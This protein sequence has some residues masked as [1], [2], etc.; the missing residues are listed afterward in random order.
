MNNKV[1][2]Q[3]FGFEGLPASG[4]PVDLSGISNETKAN[5]PSL[6]ALIPNEAPSFKFT[7]YFG[8]C[9]AGF[10][11]VRWRVDLKKEFSIPGGLRFQVNVKYSAEE[12]VTSPL[13]VIAPQEKLE[14]I[15]WGTL[16]MELEK[17]VVIQ[18]Y[19][20]WNQSG[21]R[22]WA[23]VEV[24]LSGSEGVGVKYSGLQVEYAELSPFHGSKDDQ[25]IVTDGC[26]Y[27]YT[28]KGAMDPTFTID[29]NVSA[30][31]AEAQSVIPISRLAWSKNGNFLAALGLSKDAAY[32]TVW[33][34]KYLDPSKPKDSS[35]HPEKYAVATIPHDRGDLPEL[36]VGL[37]ISADG[38]QVAVY[39]EPTIGQWADGST[40][41]K[42]TFRF[43]LLTLRHKSTSTPK[44]DT[45]EPQPVAIVNIHSDRDEVS[46]ATETLLVRH[47]NQ[48]GGHG[49]QAS[50]RQAT[51]SYV[52]AGLPHQIFQKFVGY[53]AFLTE[54]KKSDQDPNDFGVTHL[55]HT[56]DETGGNSS[57]NAITLFVAC[58]GIYIEFFKVKA[59]NNWDNTHS[60]DLTALTPTIS[61]RVTCRMMMDATSSNTFMWLEDDGAC[62]SIWDLREGSNISYVF[63]PVTAKIDSPTF[64]GNST[65]SISPDE[66][67]VALANIDGILTT[68]YA[69][70]GVEISSWR[71]HG[72]R[73]EYIAFNGWGNRLFVFIRNMMTCKLCPWILD[74]FEL[75]S[76][77]PV[78]QVP[79]PVIGTTV[80]VFLRDG[81]FKNEG[82]VCEA[83]GSEIRCYVTREPVVAARNNVDVANPTD[84]SLLMKDDKKQRNKD[85]PK[86][87]TNDGKKSEINN[88]CQSG[89]QREAVRGP[90]DDNKG[91]EVRTATEE[92]ISRN[93]S[94]CWVLGVKVVEMDLDDQSEKVIFSFV[95]EPWMRITAADIRRLEGLQKVYILP[96]RKRFVVV[97][98]Q[99][100]QVWSLPKNENDDFNL[101]F[102]WSRPKVKSD[103]EETIRKEAF[104]QNIEGMV[105]TDGDPN[106][107]VTKQK[108]D[109]Q[110]ATDQKPS[111][112]SVI[113]EE[114]SG[115]KTTTNR[116]DNKSNTNQGKPG[117][118][119]AETEPVGEYYHFIRHSIIFQDR[120]T[121]EVEAY[122]KLTIGSGTDVVTIPGEHSGDFYTEFVNCGQSIHL[123]SA[124]YAY[125]IQESKTSQ[126][127]L[128]KTPFTFREHADAIARFTRRHI[129]R[130]LPR[131]YFLPS[132]L[133]K[134][135][136]ADQTIQFQETEHIIP[137][138]AVSP[139]TS[140]IPETVIQKSDISSHKLL[141]P[142]R[143][144]LSVDKA[145]RRQNSLLRKVVYSLSSLQ[146]MRPTIESLAQLKALIEN[147][148]E[149]LETE[150]RSWVPKDGRHHDSLTVLTLLLDE[151]EMSDANHI[152]IEGLFNTSG[153]AWIPHPN[154]ALNP[155]ERVIDIRNERLLNTLID[156]CIK[157]AH[158]HHPGYL[159]PVIQCLSQLSRLY[160]DIVGNLFRKASYIPA[161]NPEYVT[162]HA[163]VA[164]GSFSK[165]LNLL[166]RCFNWKPLGY[167]DI[168]QYKN[169]VF[170]TQF[171][172]HLYRHAG[173]G[174]TLGCI[175]YFLPTF[176]IDL[177]SDLVPGMRK[178]F[179]PQIKHTEHIQPTGANRLRKVYVSP[180]QFKPVSERN[181]Q[182][183]LFLLSEVA[184]KTSIDS[185]AVE[186]SLRFKW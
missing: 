93:G 57:N 133:T 163:I 22:Q 171:Q 68:F 51:R 165:L 87:E 130:V 142:L 159:T 138:Q 168:N 125:S 84:A 31:R 132:P 174:S 58:N 95:P 14:E 82:L 119:L 140:A 117:V 7:A 56:G 150:P 145:S 180:F 177:V 112:I 35:I 126:D 21:E 124:C 75:S 186:T 114:T 161:R 9:S 79:V 182:R 181:R 33:E 147:I 18:P 90:K 32:I 36:S 135:K 89:S 78:N 70:T 41:C 153:H 129:N 113:C 66:S 60:I 172:L 34:M 156:Y 46:A 166:D 24:A 128:G 111:G 16:D 61:R 49:I 20:S 149:Y 1:D 77:I 45:S 94:K 152:F 39:Q 164:N 99:T 3:F 109:E 69:S 118:K 44:E 30:I 80:L 19:Q 120:N 25:G 88:D 97:G 146:G 105:A 52:P 131:E 169:P 175:W 62:C 160:P 184:G 47:G 40:L 155:I 67:M 27:K 76:R 38:D 64:R 83:N 63:N 158:D 65:M 102:I 96:G 59:G 179:F 12:N 167:S 123:L 134:D 81:H 98:M 178:S 100:L 11:V 162:S 6:P 55:A 72:H 23:T 136:A 101:L 104:N 106:E 148:P 42:S 144:G 141:F 103:L 26:V 92:T 143:L 170:T 73:I 122:I 110:N 127:D 4:T 17:T 151:D 48:T 157:N 74:P 29:M 28:V 139:S 85:D 91:Y 50:E 108:N 176:D 183:E 53:G 13:N 37:A 43:Q 5:Q 185:P 8:E 115:R 116:D 173:L 15:G 71:F 121:G 154:M 54:T 137:L 86:P 107:N 10:Y 2:R